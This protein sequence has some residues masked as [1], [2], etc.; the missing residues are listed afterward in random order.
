MTGGNYVNH[1]R[2]IMCLRTEAPDPLQDF[3]NCSGPC[4]PCLAFHFPP[5]AKPPE[6]CDDCYMCVKRD[7]LGRRAF[8]TDGRFADNCDGGNPNATNG[9]ALSDMDLQ[10]VEANEHRCYAYGAAPQE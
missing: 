3:V 7:V 8:L 10:Y 4:R 5:M 2:D 1:L 9:I 6:A